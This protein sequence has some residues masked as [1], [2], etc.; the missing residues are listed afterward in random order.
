MRSGGPR[1]AIERFYRFVAGDANWE[2][3]DPELRERVRASADTYHELERG[4]IATHLP[5][6]PTLAAISTPI[7]LLIGEQSLPYF[8]QAAGRLA[9]RLRVEITSTDDTHLGYLDHPVELAETIV[10]PPPAT[11]THHPP[12]GG[13]GGGG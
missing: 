2:G 5:D 4:L 8:A 11:S 7:Q 12:R 3:L 1:E 9:T 10:R 6:E 13:G